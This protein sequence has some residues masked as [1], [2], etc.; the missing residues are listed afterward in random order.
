VDARFLEAT[1]VD[2]SAL[3]QRVRTLLASG[4]REE[5]LQGM[6]LLLFAEPW[7]TELPGELHRLAL[8]LERI[9]AAVRAARTASEEAPPPEPPSLEVSLLYGCRGNVLTAEVHAEAQAEAGTAEACV[10]EVDITPP[11]GVVSIADCSFANPQDEEER[12]WRARVVAEAFERMER[13]QERYDTERKAYGERLDRL[14][15]LYPQGPFLCV[16]VTQTGERARWNLPVQLY[17]M[18]AGGT[19][20]ST[21]EEVPD[22]EASPL[23]EKLLLDELRVPYL[24][25]G[26]AV[27]V[28]RKEA[29]YE[30]LFYGAVLAPDAQTA[31]DFVRRR[32]QQQEQPLQEISGELP[33]VRLD[34]ASPPD[35]NLS[36]Y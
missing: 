10:M 18:P 15:E 35:C 23:V 28:C 21:A 14:R 13:D 5:A 36:C 11:R 33:H 20:C 3:R 2:L 19:E 26:D 30:E 12:A 17:S 22:T 32:E 25:P 6:E 8:E 9:P 27:V 29:H 24:M 31:A 7:D 34:T 1:P 4:S 16:T